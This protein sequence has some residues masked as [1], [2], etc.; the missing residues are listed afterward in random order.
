V[1]EGKTKANI[2]CK[3]YDKASGICAHSLSR[4]WCPPPLEKSLSSQCASHNCP[5]TKPMPAHKTYARPQNLCPPTKP[6]PAHKTYARPPPPLALTAFWARR[7]P[8]K[9]ERLTK[10]SG[11]IDEIQTFFVLPLSL[12]KENQSKARI[13]IVLVFA[14][15][16]CMLRLRSDCA[17]LQCQVLEAK[18]RVK[19]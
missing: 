15:V 10:V 9:I 19:P 14:L 7:S 8:K 2:T 12:G 17:S 13:W 16:L 1:K 3:S 11:E 6:M 18:L 4:W 5:P